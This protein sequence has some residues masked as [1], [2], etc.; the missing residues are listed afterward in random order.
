MNISVFLVS[1]AVTVARHGTPSS[2]AVQICRIIVA[3]ESQQCDS[4]HRNSI[5]E[6]IEAMNENELP[7][8]GTLVATGRLNDD[9]AARQTGLARLGADGKTYP[10]GF[11]HFSFN[12][13]N[14]SGVGGLLIADNT[15]IPLEFITTTAVR[16][17]QAQRILYGK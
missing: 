7:D 11:L 4:C 10:V 15:G 6:G 1:P 14:G 3:R 8:H 9:L 12:H 17:T 5:G 13:S 2:V 16:T